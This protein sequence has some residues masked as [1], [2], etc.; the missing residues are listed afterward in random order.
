MHSTYRIL[1][2]LFAILAPVGSASLAAQAPQW[3]TY[4][5]PADGFSASFPSAPQLEGKN[6]PASAS[7][8]E[9]HSYCAQLQSAHLC[10]AVFLHA[11][12]TFG[13]EGDALIQ[14]IKMGDVDSLTGHKTRELSEKP[15]ALGGNKGVALE[16]E[17]DVIHASIRIYQAGDV[18]YQTIVAS[19]IANRSADSDRFLDSF[20]LIA[21]T[22]N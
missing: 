21:R 2:W 7:S 20:Q 19:P 17:N 16:T 1:P 22:Q 4:S 5:Y 13:L 3:Q 9:L 18:I 6:Q 8:L 14:R 10:I 11:S 12:E 15:I